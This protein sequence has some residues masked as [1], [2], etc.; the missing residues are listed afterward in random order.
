M[1]VTAKFDGRIKLLAGGEEHLAVPLNLQASFPTGRFYRFS[2]GSG[3][4]V[5]S[6]DLGSGD[7]HF[8]VTNAP[9]SY[10]IRANSMSA[11][12]NF[13]VIGPFVGLVN[14]STFSLKNVTAHPGGNVVDVFVGL[15]V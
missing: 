4:S 1:S 3:V 8:V 15:S 9:K 5:L 12:T 14:S 10:A 11:T 7:A 13:P 2:L 6:I